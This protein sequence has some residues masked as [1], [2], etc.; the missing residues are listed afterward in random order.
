M[1]RG[2]V[3]RFALTLLS[4]VITCSPSVHAREFHVPDDVPEVE[5]YQ[6][7][8]V[9][10]PFGLSGL[11]WNQMVRILIN[12]NIETYRSNHQQFLDTY[13][14]DAFFDDEAAT[15]SSPSAQ[16]RDYPAGTILVKEN[17]MLNSAGGRGEPS[18]LTIMIKR[19]PG[20]DRASGDWEFIQTSP[21]GKTMLRGGAGQPAVNAACVQC[22]SH[23]KERDFVFST[24]STRPVP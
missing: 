11:H 23:M 6:E 12:R 4:A 15:P 5:G 7:W 17:Y 10:S 13:M 8:Q 21:D 24:Q 16:F 20:H 2:L 3:T 19:K 14:S 22:H 18:T 9:V 1:L